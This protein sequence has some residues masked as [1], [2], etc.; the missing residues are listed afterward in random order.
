MR[1]IYIGYDP[2]EDVAYNVAVRSLAYYAK[3]V[4]VHPI[5]DWEMRARKMYWRGYRVDEKGQMYDDRDGKPFSTQFA[6]TRFC[7]PMLARQMDINDP[8][9]FMDCDVLLRADVNELFDLWDDTYSVMCV[10]HDHQPEEITKMDGVAQTRY[11]RKNWSS[12][13]LIHPDK[14][15]L[16]TTYM[17]NRSSGA[18]LH[19][20]C[21]LRITRS[22]RYRRN[23][24]ISCAG[25]KR[26]R[27]RIRSWCIS[28]RESRRCPAM[29]PM[30]MPTNG[31]AM[32]EAAAPGLDC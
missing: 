32:P 5:M 7:V 13:F 22:A 17:V 30:N 24:T 23:G 21:G 4:R 3:G 20:S 14:V 25:P 11:F 8:V 15:P 6:F 2:R 10:H 1:H 29:N 31:A 18:H 12:V 28:R 19:G 27:C 26:T 16:L 9:L